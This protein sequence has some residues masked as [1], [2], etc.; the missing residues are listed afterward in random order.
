MT[1]PLDGV[2]IDRLHDE[3]PSMEELED[4]P[5]K[6][7]GYRDFVS[8]VAS[9]SD[10]FAVRR[11][12][13]LHSRAILTLQDHLVEI[14]E[15]LDE[16]D[17]K[18]S[19]KGVKV[20]GGN[21]PEVVESGCSRQ[22]RKEGEDDG[23]DVS[24]IRDINNGTI[25]DDMP[26][27]AVLVSEMIGKIAEYAQ[28]PNRN[29]QNLQAWVYNNKGAIT[30]SET[31][32][33]KHVDELVAISQP[34]STLRHWFELRIVYGTRSCLG[35][36]R[37]APPHAKMSSR[38]QEDTY[39]FSQQS[40]DAFS[41]IA[42]FVAALAMLIT[43]LWILQTLQDLRLKLAV[44]TV[45][46]VVC[47]AFLTFATLGRPFER[48]AATA[49]YLAVLVVFLQV[50]NS[51]QILQQTSLYPEALIRRPCTEI[52]STMNC[53]NCGQRI[54]VGNTATTTTHDT[55]LVCYHITTEGWLGQLDGAVRSAWS[56]RRVQ[57][58]QVAVL[59]LSW[60]ETDMKFGDKEITRLQSILEDTY[61][62]KVVNWKIPS[63]KPKPKATRKYLDFAEE[64]GASDS[65]LILYYAGH[66]KSGDGQ[67]PTWHSNR[68]D[69]TTAV[70]E[71]LYSGGL[72]S[73]VPIAGPHSFTSGLLD[74]LARAAN[75]KMPLSVT[76]LHSRL[77]NRFQSKLPS[78]V[79]DRDDRVVMSRGQVVMTSENRIT[80]LHTFLAAAKSPR[81]ISLSP[82][83]PSTTSHEN[84]NESDDDSGYSDECPSRS[85]WP[86]VLIAV[87]LVESSSLKDD[88][89]QWIL[90]A[91]TGVVEFKGIYESYSSLLLVELPVAVWDL[92]PPCDAVSFIGFTRSPKEIEVATQSPSKAMQRHVPDQ[93]EVQ[94][95]LNRREWLPREFSIELK[96]QLRKQAVRVVNDKAVDLTDILRLI[97]QNQTF[98]LHISEELLGLISYYPGLPS[99]HFK[100]VSLDSIKK[101]TSDSMLS[102]PF[103]I[104]INENFLGLASQYPGISSPPSKKRRLDFPNSQ[105]GPNEGLLERVTS[106]YY[107]ARTDSNLVCP[108]IR[109]NP[110]TSHPGITSAAITSFFNYTKA[111]AL[112]FLP[113][114]LFHDWAKNNAFT[115][116]PEDLMLLDSISVLA[117]CINNGSS[118][119]LIGFA[120]DEA[121]RFACERN[122]P[123][124]QLIQTKL[125]LS[126][127]HLAQA[128]ELD[129]YEC[130]GG[131]I[132]LA[133]SLQYNVDLNMVSEPPLSDY[134]YGMNRATYEESRKRTLYSCFIL[135]RTNG[136]FPSRAALLKPEDIFLRLPCDE[137]WFNTNMTTSWETPFFDIKNKLP[138]PALGLG[139]M[140]YVV[141]IAEVW[142]RVLAGVQKEA[143]GPAPVESDPRFIKRIATR[144][145]HIDAAL[146]ARF[147]YEESSLVQATDEHFDGT[148]ITLHLMLLLTRIKFSRHA[149][150]EISRV[151]Q[152]KDIFQT[153]NNLAR[154]LML[155]IT[156]LR[157]QHMKRQH[158]TNPVFPS[159]FIVQAAVESIDI[160]SANGV[161]TSLPV[162]IQE[163]KVVQEL[164]HSVC[165]VWRNER[166]HMEAL[167]KRADALC[168]LR[169]RFEQGL[170]IDI[171]GCEIF[172]S[173]AQSPVSLTSSHFRFMDAL[174]KRFPIRLDAI[175]GPNRPM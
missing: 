8:Y 171:T 3:A 110:F 112:C 115:K 65:L 124:L 97:S 56:K 47:L 152:A 5:W 174:E 6:F 164:C 54:G 151:S 28:A 172:Q 49:G 134:P 145:R 63:D 150:S 78:T 59:M 142:G 18:Y 143:Q 76:E 157:N 38:D 58:S 42:I 101:V 162:L 26:R 12:D 16:L 75:L 41:G 68:S 104:H 77:I 96:R 13:R 24:S 116:S 67:C 21:P 32:F 45:F 80:P 125:I 73:K 34:K 138:N 147:R 7:I 89:E 66:A 2:V 37:R 22:G 137:K 165:S 131:A 84:A 55:S 81:S 128:R 111:A 72:D 154:D 106:H 92:L 17:T 11:F 121:P 114:R 61:R 141:I 161:D 29:V 40:L 14:E 60:E 98:Q 10:F 33:I 44:I 167:D 62:Y 25:R 119:E 132:S 90:T 139:I 51:N 19:S 53:S 39:L 123:G 107:P 135:E 35:L 64:Y 46:A 130:L 149:Q 118:M 83:S 94:S 43:P 127:Y 148:L 57:Y 95:T 74:E 144:I 100:K 86:K 91:P 146:P 82:L 117:T 158:T 166:S 156:A 88:L 113:E 168:L 85:S 36:F 20:R 27:R 163:V 93:G 102:E 31:E 170:E 87:R 153:C 109:S 69:P 9:D 122:T 70:V 103:Q 160:I 30:D 99:Y 159:N 105:P 155:L 136:L 126:L 140:A 48:L 4:S 79:C 173:P 23:S 129:S 120:H 169:S 1:V 133:L 15:K 52:A 175:Y 71:C 108:D 50:G